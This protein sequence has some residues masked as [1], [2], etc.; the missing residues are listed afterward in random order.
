ML[1]LR[2]GLR[3]SPCPCSSGYGHA[4]RLCTPRFMAIGGVDSRLCCQLPRVELLSA[5][6]AGWSRPR[7]C[8]VVC[9]FVIRHSNQAD[10]ESRLSLR[11]LGTPPYCLMIGRQ[12]GRQAG[13]HHH[14]HG[15]ARCD[16][17]R[18]DTM[19]H[20]ATRC[21]TMRCV[22]RGQDRPRGRAREGEP[23]KER[24]AAKAFKMH[25]QQEHQ[26]RRQ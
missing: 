12:A 3:S 24:H 15:Q 21:D 17:T 7:L 14:E 19:R 9:N 4:G 23:E 2:R 5:A 18:R 8:L 10:P 1:S 16:A 6:W 13:H 25:E 22:Q 11:L 20:G 26:K